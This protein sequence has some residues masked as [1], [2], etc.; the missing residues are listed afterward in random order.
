M[1]QNEGLTNEAL[2]PENILHDSKKI[3]APELYHPVKD[4][5]QLSLNLTRDK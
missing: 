4:P 2:H 3:P 5:I 1:K